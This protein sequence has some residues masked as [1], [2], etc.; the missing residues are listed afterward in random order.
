MSS[1]LSEL[2]VLKPQQVEWTQ[3]YLDPHNPRLT[4]VDGEVGPLNVPDNEI[5]GE[6]LQA[7]LL[8]R[9]RK[10][11]AIDELT[12]KIK[13]LGFLPID[14]IVVRP[15]SSDPNSFV[16][17]EGNRRVASIRSIHS[18]QATLATLQQEVRDSI[19]S[20]QVLVYD[21]GDPEIAWELQGL[22]HMGGVRAWGPY[23]QARF[24]VDLKERRGLEV[25]D[26]AQIAGLGR[27]VASRLLRSY[28]GFEEARNDPDF[29][30]QIGEQD[31]SIFQEATFHRNQSPIWLWLDW[32]D[33]THTFGNQGNL[34]TLL[35]LLK[36]PSEDTNEPRITRVNP[37]LRDKFGRL[38]TADSS[39][40]LEAFLRDDLS[41]DQ[42][43]Q[44][45]TAD[46][47]HGAGELADLGF[48][49]SQLAGWKERAS[50]LPLPSIVESSREDE[51]TSSLEA[52]VKTLTIQI[53]L[54][55]GHEDEG[56]DAP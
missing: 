7:E 13:K 29:G 55:K 12:E 39:D 34:T 22:R 45:V 5:P 51:F 6:G 28:Y 8:A 48:W 21:G 35:R 49:K 2:L 27:T 50:N 15:L 10:E 20:F 23:Q 56:S 40:T 14:R 19:S 26:V 53:S 17:L 52:L 18:S 16:V 42:A 38:L 32:N 41:L 36:E 33:S 47:Q 54:L 4:G 9:L 43:Y 11:Q 37:D 30:D 44:K 24:L 46:D 3:V 1:D 31:F 25:T